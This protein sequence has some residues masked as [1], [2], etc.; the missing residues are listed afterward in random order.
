M[1]CGPFSEF[2]LRQR[3]DMYRTREDIADGET[4]DILEVAQAVVHIQDSVI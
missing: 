1:P 2:P 4:P 3:E